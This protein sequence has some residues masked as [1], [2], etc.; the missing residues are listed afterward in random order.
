MLRLTL[1]L[2]GLLAPASHALAQGQSG[3]YTIPRGWYLESNLGSFFRIG[4]VKHCENECDS[5]SPATSVSTSSVQ[6]FVGF[7]VGK[8]L[9]PSLGAQ[10]LIG[11]GFVA[12]GAV[13]TIDE[14]WISNSD[15]SQSLLPPQD[16]S[17]TFF[18]VQGTYLTVLESLR[19]GLELKAGG[20][21]VIA[22]NG[23]VA[24]GDEIIPSDLPT[25]STHVNV[26]GGASIKYL[27]LL[28][29]FVV[30]VDVSGGFVMVKDRGGIPYVS[31]SPALNY[32]F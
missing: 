31:I 18:N 24:V 21:L 9:T 32:V 19:L 12:G 28:T 26:S 8:D 17:M 1:V 22:S 2:I 6:P 20:G 5:G 27:T 14:W 15:E 11:T 23:L 16:Y 30:G 29:G 3:D 10:M 25:T 7:T 13:G 4:G